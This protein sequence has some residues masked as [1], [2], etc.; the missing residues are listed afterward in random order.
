MPETDIQQA[1]RENVESFRRTLEGI[2]EAIGE[3]DYRKAARLYQ[4][5]SVGAYHAWSASMKATQAK[6][7]ES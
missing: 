2:E 6:P 7:Q 4:Q 3:E 5:L 1:A